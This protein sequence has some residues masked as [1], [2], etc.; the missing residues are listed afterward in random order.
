MVLCGPNAL[1]RAGGAAGREKMVGGRGVK[2]GAEEHVAGVARQVAAGV[3]G[4]GVQHHR[5]DHEEVALV[6]QHLDAAP[7]V[8]LWSELL[9]DRTPNA[10]QLGERCSEQQERHTALTLRQQRRWARARSAGTCMRRGLRS[11]VLRS[12]LGSC[13]RWWPS[14]KRRTERLE[15]RD[16]LSYIR[17]KREE[18]R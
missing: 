14:L 18:G 10:A 8:K 9:L 15:S 6:K 4:C 1:H 2:E 13:R 7:E 11:S 5:V 16:N 3:W 12:R 17:G